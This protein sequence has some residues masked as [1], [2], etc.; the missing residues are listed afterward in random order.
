MKEE[1]KAAF[2]LDTDILYT[3]DVHEA[4]SDRYLDACLHL[5]IISG[6]V[7][8][9]LSDTT[10]VAR[11]SDCIIKPG[12]NPI[13]DIKI[14]DDFSM[15]GVI[16]SNRYLRLCSIDESY[17]AKGELS[18]LQNPI[19]HMTQVEQEQILADIQ[20]VRSRFEASYH[21]FYMQV[22][23]RSA[24]TLILDLQDIHSRLAPENLSGVSQSA[25]ILRNF[26]GHLQTGLFYHERK[27][28]YYAALLF[29]TPKYLSE[30]SVKASGHNA[31]YWIDRYTTWEIS[32]LMLDTSLSFTQ[33][34]ERMNFSSMNYFTRYVKRT[35]GM[36]PTEYRRHITGKK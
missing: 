1:D 6:Q 18:M 19:M 4:M 33:I 8:F 28:D 26:I 21:T 3:E 9:K 16:I 27:V 32:K 15:Q 31:S 35:L 20:Q 22:L 10:Y 23:K 5:V 2:V 7:S 25:R 34:A 36:S 14:S 24:E 17:R 30:A 29:I 13:S 12:S 11:T